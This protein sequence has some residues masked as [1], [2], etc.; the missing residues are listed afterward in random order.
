MNQLF[1]IL[2]IIPK[3]SGETRDEY[4]ER[5]IQHHLEPFKELCQFN[6][7]MGLM[8]EPLS[9]VLVSNKMTLDDFAYGY[10]QSCFAEA[11][12]DEMFDLIDEEN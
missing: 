8:K 5:I 3:R 9:K 2:E 6:E 4:R 1:D 12:T 10:V 7:S 11:V